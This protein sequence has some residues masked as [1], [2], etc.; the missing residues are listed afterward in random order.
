[1]RTRLRC[2]ISCRLLLGFVLNSGGLFS[3]VL[4][5][6]CTKNSIPASRRLELWLS[7]W[8]IASEKNLHMRLKLHYR[9]SCRNDYYNYRHV[10]AQTGVVKF[11]IRTVDVLRLKIFKQKTA[12]Q[13]RSSR[14]E[15]VSY[16]GYSL[17]IRSY[18]STI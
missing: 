4:I 5:S 11:L 17:Q 8:R 2:L 9:S 10:F 16:N 3:P 12:T 7:N 15:S 13:Y 18:W 6:C 14:G 1:V